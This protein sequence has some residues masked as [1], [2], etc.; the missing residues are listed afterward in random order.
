MRHPGHPA[1]LLALALLGGCGACDEDESV[2]RAAA[3]G[4]ADPSQDLPPRES[5]L[6]VQAGDAPPRCLAF[7]RR[8]LE[9]AQAAGRPVPPGA[10]DC[11]ASCASGGTHRSAPEAVWDC[12]DAPCGTAFE[13]CAMQ[14]MM[15]HMRRSE[16]AVF[17]ITC[18]GLCNKAAWCAERTG[19]AAGP[20]GEDC[21][22]ACRAGGAY[23]GVEPREFRCAEAP[24]GAAFVSCRQ[25]GGP[26]NEPPRVPGAP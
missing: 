9:C 12:A 17:P 23:A 2:D 25:S 21:E 15:Q 14:A 10:S 13:G 3:V 6:P 26:R 18:V 22:A 20:G 4:E 7:C 16:V 1:A 24:C 19:G 8:S 5:R 11:D